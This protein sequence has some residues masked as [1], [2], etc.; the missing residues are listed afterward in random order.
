MDILTLRKCFPFSKLGTSTQRYNPYEDV[1]RCIRIYENKINKPFKC[2]IIKKTKSKQSSLLK[3]MHIPYIP[4]KKDC[5][6]YEMYKKNINIHKKPKSISFCIHNTT[7][8]KSYV[9]KK[10]SYTPKKHRKV[11]N[12]DTY[13]KLIKCV[14]M[15]LRESKEV[16]NG[17]CFERKTEK[18]RRKWL[19]D[20]DD[21]DELKDI[22]KGK[23]WKSMVCFYDYKKGM[24][25]VLPKEHADLMFFC[26]LQNKLE[27]SRF[28]KRRKE[29]VEGYFDKQK[30]AEVVPKRKE[31]KGE[32]KKKERVKLFLQKQM[33]IQK[34]SLFLS[35]KKMNL[36][37]KIQENMEKN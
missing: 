8:H 34:A 10:Y 9:D 33:Y 13:K 4:N 36:L 11:D 30:A 3:E 17:I 31:L 24:H 25:V 35:Y 28:Y 2:S 14:N 18:K 27:D 5:T 1:S 16:G 26:D 12:N 20:D 6:L 21:E 15:S 19:L 7:K 29:V 23:E 37:Q 32:I 22:Y